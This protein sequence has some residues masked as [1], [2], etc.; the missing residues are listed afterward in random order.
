MQE[1]VAQLLAESES[2]DH[3]FELCDCDK[4]QA[5]C[6]LK[7]AIEELVWRTVTWSPWP[8]PASIPDILGQ[9]ILGQ[10]DG[11]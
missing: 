10:P 3:H 1:E 5:C 11:S 2:W 8:F 6:L 7:T 4:T 9:D